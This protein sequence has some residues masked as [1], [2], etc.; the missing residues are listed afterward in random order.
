MSERVLTVKQPWADLVMVDDGAGGCLK[1]VENRGWPVPS[2][3]PRHSQCET[4]PERF[5]THG[6]GS[7][8]HCPGLPERP[9]AWSMSRDLGPFPFRLWIHAGKQMDRGA[10]EAWWRLFAAT[11][12]MRHNFDRLGVLLGSVLVAGCHHAD[13]CLTHGGDDGEVVASLVEVEHCSRW[14]EP[15]AYHW[16]FTDPQ[17][18]DT[19]IPMRGRQGLWT[20]EAVPA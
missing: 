14:A 3:L 18:L 17:P 20:L 4:C 16:Q 9:G 1:P 13:G 15:D 6:I 11:G 5:Y 8:R 12:R 2:T 10:T 19:P 7:H